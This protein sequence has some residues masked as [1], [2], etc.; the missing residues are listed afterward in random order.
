MLVGFDGA[1]VVHR[2]LLRKHT[3]GVLIGLPTP[4]FHPDSK[5]SSFPPSNVNNNLPMQQ[6]Q[7]I[8]QDPAANTPKTQMRHNSSPGNI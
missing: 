7:G 3:D 8:Y 2:F 5:P 1:H 6:S 4:V